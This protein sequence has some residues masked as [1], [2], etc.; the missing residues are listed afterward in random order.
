MSS[1]IP[2]HFML[3]KFKNQLNLKY[4]ICSSVSYNFNIVTQSKTHTS[5]M[6]K[7][8]LYHVCCHGNHCTRRTILI[9]ITSYALCI[10]CFIKQLVNLCLLHSLCSSIDFKLQET[11]RISRILVLPSINYSDLKTSTSLYIN[12]QTSST[13][14]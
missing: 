13:V 8:Y 9:L 14:I 7:R 5:L 12:V 2:E 3:T 10:A 4:L 6:V 11:Q 1:G